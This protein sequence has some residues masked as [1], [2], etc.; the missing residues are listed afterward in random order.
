[1]SVPEQNSSGATR[2]ESTEVWERTE[3]ITRAFPSPAGP[4]KCVAAVGKG[5]TL[6]R[7]H[8][9]IGCAGWQGSVTKSCHQPAG[10]QGTAT[11]VTVRAPCGDGTSVPA[12]GHCRSIWA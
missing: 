9:A 6:G 7:A 11:A 5:I 4:A 1:M 3:I 8:R 2:R 12:E 10:S